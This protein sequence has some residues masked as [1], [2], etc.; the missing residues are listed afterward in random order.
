LNRPLTGN[1]DADE[2]NTILDTL[3]EKDKQKYN[4]LVRN[5]K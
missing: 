2:V 5:E 4:E 3:K 1:P